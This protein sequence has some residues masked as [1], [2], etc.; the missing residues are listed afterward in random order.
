MRLSRY[1]GRF[2]AAAEVPIDAA[3]LVA[4]IAA[5]AEVRERERQEAIAC[6]LSGS[7]GWQQALSVLGGTFA[8]ERTRPPRNDD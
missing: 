6:F 8:T 7:E 2:D 4:E 3:D 5:R 1:D